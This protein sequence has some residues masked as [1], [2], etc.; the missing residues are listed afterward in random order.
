MWHDYGISSMPLRNPYRSREKVDQKGPG[1]IANPS[2]LAMYEALKSKFATL[3]IY[4]P[5]PMEVAEKLRALAHWDYSWELREG[6][7]EITLDLTNLTR[8]GIAENIGGM[9]IRIENSTGRIQSVT[10]NGQPHDA[11]S[12]RVVILPNLKPEKNRVRVTLSAAGAAL[13]HL[14][15]VSKRMPFVRRA[16]KGMEFQLLTKSKARFA[17]E[18]PSAGI[19]LHADWQEY[20][21]QGDGQLSGYVTSDRTLRF[22]PLSSPGFALTSA[23]VPIG[24]LISHA[25]SLTLKLEKG[26]Q[27]ER[28]MAFTSARQPGEFQLNGQTLAPVVSGAEY[29]LTLPEYQAPATLVVRW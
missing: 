29:R 9:G 19:V 5:E 4:C 28:Q 26:S 6:G 14:T 16:G 18:V 17:L 25:D 21:R 1:R 11:F 2:N 13:P 12:E 7:L 3:P 10:I 15:Y 27:P 23:T 8:P 22:Q 20:N 24:E